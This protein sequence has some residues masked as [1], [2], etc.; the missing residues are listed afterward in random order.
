MRHAA[1]NAGKK[2]ANKHQ[3]AAPQVK[4]KKYEEEKEIAQMGARRRRMVGGTQL[5]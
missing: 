3:L 5:S 4:K 1:R 2:R